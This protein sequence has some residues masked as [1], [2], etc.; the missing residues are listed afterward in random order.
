[1]KRYDSVELV[2]NAQHWGC[3]LSNA[4]DH[5]RVSIDHYEIHERAVDAHKPKDLRV[6]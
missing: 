6:R 4:R 3:G 5:G 1:V 2:G